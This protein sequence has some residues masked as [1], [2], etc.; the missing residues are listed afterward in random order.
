MK[1][2]YLLLFVICLTGA[3]AQITVVITPPAGT[4]PFCTNM[5][6]SFTG[7]GTPGPILAWQWTSSPSAGANIQSPNQNIT[8]ITFTNAGTYTLT[9]TA[10]DNSGRIDSGKYALTV[11]ACSSNISAYNFQETFQ[12]FPNP[13]SD[14][15]QINNLEQ[16]IYSYKLINT[17]GEVCAE[18]KLN[19]T[20]GEINVSEISNG[21]YFLFL[22]NKEKFKIIIQH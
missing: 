17:I 3:N 2:L 1:K 7:N 8:N 10:L 14:V 9:L 12:I 21:I 18:G 13:V 19:K 16:K 4:P 20:S 5:P 6:Y 22:D 15:L 11:T